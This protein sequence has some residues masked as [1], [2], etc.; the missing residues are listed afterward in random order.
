[1]EPDSSALRALFYGL[2]V[3]SSFFGATFFR[4]KEIGRGSEQIL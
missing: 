3:H 1:M 4:V 2:G